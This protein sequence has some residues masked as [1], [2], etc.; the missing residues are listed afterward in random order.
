MEEY[1]ECGLKWDVTLR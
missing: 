1:H